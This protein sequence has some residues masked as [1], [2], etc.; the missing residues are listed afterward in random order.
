MAIDTQQ[1]PVAAVRR[2]V[3]VVMILVMDREFT[4]FLAREFAPAPC[5]DPWEQLERSLP[6]GP[7]PTFSLAP[8]L[9]NKLIQS[10]VI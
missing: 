4:E 3:L 5:A 6:I 9:G 8:G 1:L 2:V 7:L 10:V